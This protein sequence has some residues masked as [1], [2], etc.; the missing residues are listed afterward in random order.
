MMPFQT[1]KLCSYAKSCPSVS[2]KHKRQLNQ[3]VFR[4]SLSV[5][6]LGINTHDSHSP[7]KFGPS[8]KMLCFQAVGIILKPP[9]TQF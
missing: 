7:S 4:K 5:G 9:A 6:I 3:I 1:L 2:V 8:L